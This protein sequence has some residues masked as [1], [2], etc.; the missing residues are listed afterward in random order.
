M[1]T[2]PGLS[3][4]SPGSKAV[5]PFK[6]LLSWP[7][8]ITFL[9]IPFPPIPEYNQGVN[10]EMEQFASRTGLAERPPTVYSPRV[11]C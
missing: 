10:P 3:L 1:M 4:L 2:H 9:Y 8:R 6:G 5:T 11:P 7:L